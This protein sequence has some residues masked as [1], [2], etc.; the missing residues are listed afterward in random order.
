MLER[1]AEFSG[2]KVTL[3]QRPIVE[4]CTFAHAEAGQE[5]ATFAV[6]GTG[7]YDQH[8]TLATHLASSLGSVVEGGPSLIAATEPG[9]FFI[10]QSVLT[11][12]GVSSGIAAQALDGLKSS[13]G[14]PAITDAFQ[15]FSITFRR[16]V[17]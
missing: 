15:G 7:A 16:K 5:L 6:S 3:I 11:K 17:L 2:Q 9:G 14:S 10:D 8:A 1:A 13:T 4:R 12:L